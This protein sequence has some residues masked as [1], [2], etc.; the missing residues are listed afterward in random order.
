MEITKQ[1]NMVISKALSSYISCFFKKK[2]YEVKPFL[3][4]AYRVWIPYSNNVL[5]GSNQLRLL[6]IKSPLPLYTQNRALVPASFAE[7]Q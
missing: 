2:N 6:S 1:K 7:T 5:V 3:S 4:D